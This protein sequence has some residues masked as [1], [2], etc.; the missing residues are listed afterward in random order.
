MKRFFTLLALSLLAVACN[1]ASRE[2]VIKGYRIHQVGGLGFGLDGLTADVLLDLDVDNP[3][4][5]RYT[6]EA[7]HADIFYAGDTV[8]YADIDLKEQ[9]SILPRSSG[10][11]SIPLGVKIKRPLSLLG[12]FL[13]D[14]QAK[15]EADFDLTL[16]KGS[17][18]KNIRKSRVPLDRILDLLGKNQQFET[19]EENE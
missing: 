2:P 12:G 10:K 17:I 1:N 7:L 8:R 16:R 13:S 5:A 6:V 11:V 14:D 3:T 15:Y 19:L 18:K 9:A 4:R